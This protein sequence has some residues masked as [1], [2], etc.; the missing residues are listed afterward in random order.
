MC[1]SI[2]GGVSCKC[3]WCTA[4]CSFSA[5]SRDARARLKSKEFRR[6]QPD[7]T[8]K[9]GAAEEVENLWPQLIPKEDS[10]QLS[11]VE[12]RP[13]VE[14]LKRKVAEVER[15][16]IERER[17]EGQGSTPSTE[18]A[19]EV[20]PDPKKRRTE[21]AH[22]VFQIDMVALNSSNS[23]IQQLSGRIKRTEDN[24]EK[25]ERALVEMTCAVSKCTDAINRFKNNMEENAKAERR[26]A[27][28]WIEM[29]RVR[30]EERRKDREAEQ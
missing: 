2:T 27:E 9:G 23:T 4:K 25:T 28:K 21:G 7:A 30:E 29:E 16:M 15:E 12:S 19:T 6:G 17:S 8:T 13:G 18:T 26:W 22:P 3:G 20:E 24:H 14:S 11:D 10:D 1:F 5:S